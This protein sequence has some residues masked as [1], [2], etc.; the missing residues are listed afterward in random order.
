MIIRSAVLEGQVPETDREEFDRLMRTE[1]LQAV[2][3]YP[4]LAR[5]V[6]RQPVECDE[7]APP[8]YMVFDLHFP[9]LQ[10]MRDALASPVRQ[11][12]R[13][14]MAPSMS[15]FQGRVYHVVSEETD[16]ISPGA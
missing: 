4:G 1:V 12:V 10:A 11:Q 3:S 13:A 15:R 9:S 6:L 7:G 14:R 16:A 2:A 8:I 5:V